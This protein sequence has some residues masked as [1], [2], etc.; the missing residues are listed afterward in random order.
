MPR[1]PNHCQRCGKYIETVKYNPYNITFDEYYCQTNDKKM[2]FACAK[3]FV[4]EHNKMKGGAWEIQE[5]TEDSEVK[6]Q[7]KKEAIDFL[8]EIRKTF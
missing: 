2:C 8:K 6:E 3:H 7:V 5:W 4:K 1:K